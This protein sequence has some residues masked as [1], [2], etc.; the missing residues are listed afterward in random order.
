MRKNY[1]KYTRFFI[2][3][4][5]LLSSFL[6]LGN[7]LTTDASIAA[8]EDYFTNRPQ[9]SDTLI[10]TESEDPTEVGHHVIIT[11][12]IV[13]PQGIFDVEIQIEG[14]I[15]S[16]DQIDSSHWEYNWT[17]S[18][19]G[20]FEYNVSY[21]DGNEKIRT[22]NGSIVVLED[23]AAP[24]Y[25][26]LKILHNP[27]ELGKSLKIS[28][29]VV[30]QSGINQ[31]L[32]EYE[33]TNHTMTDL[34]GDN[35]KYED[36]TPG[37]LGD[38]PFTIHMEDNNGNINTYEN[39]LHVVLD[40]TPPEYEIPEDL[41]ESIEMGEEFCLCI[42]VTDIYGINQV[43]IEYEG[44]NHSMVN[45]AS[46]DSWCWEGWNPTNEGTYVYTIHMEDNNNN[47]NSTSGS[48]I[49][50]PSTVINNGDDTNQYYFII[51]IVIIGGILSA[52]SVIKFKSKPK[53]RKDN[54]GTQKK[55]DKFIGYKEGK[56]ET[57]KKE[58]KVVCPI[59]NT[60]FDLKIP[61]NIINESKQL[62]TISIPKETGCEH[63]FQMF[64]DKNFI[65]RG[66]QRVDYEFKME[67][68]HNFQKE[69][70]L[71]KQ[72]M[73]EDLKK[74]KKRKNNGAKALIKVKQELEKEAPKSEET[75]IVK[76]KH[77]D[78]ESI[79]FEIRQF[80]SIP[81]ENF[82]L[83]KIINQS[84]ESD[85]AKSRIL[86][87]ILDF[88]N[89]FSMFKE[90]QPLM[91]SL[92]CYIRQSVEEKSK[93]NKQFEQAIIKHSLMGFIKEYLDYTDVQQKKKVLEFLTE[94][95]GKLALEPM[96]VNLG[97]LLKPMYQDEDYLNTLKTTTMEEVSY[98]EDGDKEKEIKN[99]MDKWIESQALDLENQDKLNEKL[100]EELI[101]LSKEFD[102]K[103]DSEL[104]RNLTLDIKDMLALKLTVLSLMGGIS[105]ESIEPIP[106]K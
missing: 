34:G 94:S 64:V 20:F 6:I 62:T 66:Y 15:I 46:I 11:A 50:L 3:S 75:E 97:L 38:Y 83:Y 55:E 19:S 36:W 13:D 18:I 25:S 95:L 14:W 87:I 8:N 96:I 71:L 49:V 28:L 80:L 58:V 92:Y 82:D 76:V 85:K 35:Y 10:V 47:W 40:A 45:I 74:L 23:I 4:T 42:V 27:L 43:L 88:I 86:E 99:I 70:V 57:D 48:L 65:V 56:E 29:K 31:V 22:F 104:F 51:I 98:L 33:G 2:I 54:F 16:M 52:F 81:D 101:K 37:S 39:I 78:L 105:D 32:I 60:D 41:V 73:I 100:L 61:K 103:V 7:S 77:E 89:K 17:P 102:M 9:L 53:S 90:I 84:Y 79:Y 24:M 59:C 44:A 69:T 63:H 26:N 30:D 106:L 72:R 91:S 21:K 1:R 67:D 93:N 12:E 5:F 68:L